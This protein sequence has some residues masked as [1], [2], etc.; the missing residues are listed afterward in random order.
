MARYSGARWL[1]I[2]ENNTQRRI[3]PTQLILHSIAAPWNED[4]V[5][6]FWNEPGINVESH[7]GVDYDGSVGQFID[8]NVRADANYNANNRAISIE[9]AANVK[10]TDPWTEAQIKTIVNI[11][12]WAHKTHGIPARICRSG[13]DPGFG[14]HRMYR[15][16]AVGGG[17]YCPGD[18][19]TRQF[20]EVVFP[21]FLAALK[22]KAPAP[23]PAPKGDWV[24]S[25]VGP[26]QTSN[27]VKVVQKALIKLKFSIPAGATGFWGAQTTAAYAAWQRSLGYKGADADGT[28]GLTSLKKLA[29]KAGFSVREA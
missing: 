4:R 27:S 20:K 21:R 17:T 7:F 24:W 25:S 22:G 5:R 18:A 29:A 3:S 15:D 8:T 13:T 11:M 14:V 2:P 28:P 10:N 12:V 6:A 26:G 9:T 23:T 19:R 16:W 1:P